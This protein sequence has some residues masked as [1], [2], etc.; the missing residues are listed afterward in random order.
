MSRELT[1]LYAAY[2]TGRPSPL[3]ELAIQYAD[4]AAWQRQLLQGETLE[5]LRSYWVKQLAGV[6]PLELPADL[7]R[8]AVRTTR[9]STLP[10]DLT[11]ELSAAV[12]EFCRREGV[13]PFMALLAA[14]EML[15]ARYAGQDDFAIGSPVANRMQPETEPLIGCFINMV[16]LRNDLSGD[17]GFREVVGRLR[18]VALAAYEHQELTLDRVVDAVRPPRDASRHPLFQV[19]FVLQNNEPP[20]LAS[21]G[22]DV[23]LLTDVS[24]G[25]LAFF[26]L[27]LGFGDTGQGF[28]GSINFNTDLFLPATIERMARHYQALLAAALRDPD[29]PLGSLPMVRGAG[30]A[31]GVGRLEL[32]G[33]RLPARGLY[34]RAVRTAGRRVA[35]GAGP[36]GRA[37]AVDVRRAGAA[38]QPVG[39]RAAGPRRRAGRPG[40]GAAAALRRMGGGGAGR[41]QGRRGLP[42]LGPQPAR[43]AAAIS[44][45]KTHASSAS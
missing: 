11:P 9:G 12:R 5:R 16:V 37:A 22:L 23:E 20:S 6:P 36:G 39:P 29:C 32:H 26:E 24:N 4:F 35:R 44:R 8:P 31:H 33:G 45:W 14:F 27:T 7:P 34:A 41:A 18:Q 13:T 19:M 17:P 30:A 3:P 38:G 40:G 28:R 21:L 42:A 15:L 1:V 25:R 2:G 43:R 10:C